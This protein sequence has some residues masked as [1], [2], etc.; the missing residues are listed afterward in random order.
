MN[1][2]GKPPP[3]TVPNWTPILVEDFDTDVAMG[4]VIGSSAYA[5]AITAYPTGWRTS[6]PWQSGMYDNGRLEVK[7]GCLISHIATVTD[8]RGTHP[9]VTA[10]RPRLSAVAPWGIHHGR[11]SVRFKA[12][13]L[14]GYKVAWLLWP[15]SGVWPR[16]GEIDFPE[17]C[18]RKDQMVRGFMHRQ[19]AT[20]GSDQAHATGATSACDG[21]W[22]TATIT[23][24]PGGWRTTECTFTWDG[25]QIG[26]TFERVPTGP[27]HWILQTEPDLH[28]KYLGVVNGHKTW[29]LPDPD[30]AGCI[31]VDWIV[32]Y[33]AE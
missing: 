24:K 17:Q 10:V 11:L 12:D 5:K 30:V 25:F 4:Q 1:R 19:D 21:E 14:P 16:D 13:E 26:K 28:P 29:E 8:A 15:D 22:H 9:R 33:Q 27:M 6:K 31:E 32:G 2:S 18:L 20:D 7:D 23:W 3:L